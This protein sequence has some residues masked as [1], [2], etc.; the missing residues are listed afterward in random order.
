MIKTIKSFIY[1]GNKGIKKVG[2]KLINLVYDSIEMDHQ[3]AEV[4][5]KRV[6]YKK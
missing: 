1:A 2:Y 4:E 5:I 6:F 3:I